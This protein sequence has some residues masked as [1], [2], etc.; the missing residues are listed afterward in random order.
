VLALKA[1]AEQVPFPLCQRKIYHIFKHEGNGASFR[2]CD[3]EVHPDCKDWVGK[4]VIV[5]EKWDGTTVQATRHGIFKRQDNFRHG[6]KA[7]RGAPVPDRYRLDLLDIDMEDNVH[8]KRAVEPHLA[9]FASLSDGLC[10]YFEAIGPAMGGG[11]TITN[12]TG[13]MILVFD[14]SMDG[15]FLPWT[16][17]ER[18][19]VAHSLPLV[20]SWRLDAF[21][22]LPVYQKLA[23]TE[24]YTSPPAGYASEPFEGFVI[25]DPDDANR[26]AKARKDTIVASGGQ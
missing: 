7:K 22:P 11:P 9:T 21:E 3:G 24:C 12:R 2:Y 26:I 17:I 1:R 19:A 6:S 14:F 18:L 16:E 8:I 10:V 4:P 15:Q 13:Y 23:N 5:T 20:S 25:R